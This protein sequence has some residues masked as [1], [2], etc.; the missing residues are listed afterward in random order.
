[1]PYISPDGTINQV[2]IRYTKKLKGEEV[3]EIK[4][5]ICPHCGSNK[6][7]ICCKKCKKFLHWRK[8]K[9]GF[10]SVKCSET[11]METSIIEKR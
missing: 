8:Y 6:H 2:V 4:R 10:C 5:Y 11:A 9:K 1:M 3:P 7:K